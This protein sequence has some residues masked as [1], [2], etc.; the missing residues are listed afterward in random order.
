M[1]PEGLLRR[2]AHGEDRRPCRRYFE[3]LPHV[4]KTVSIADYLAQLHVALEEMP[5]ERLPVTGPCPRGTRLIAQYLLVYEASGDP[6]DF[7]EEIDFD[8]QRALVRGVL[9]EAH[10]SRNRQYRGGAGAL[11]AEEFNEPG[12]RAMLSGD[13]NLSYHWMSSAAALAFQRRAPCPWPSC[14]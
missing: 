12:M 4:G 3:S 6:T 5:P 2:A 1:S 13:V 8:Y 10:F 7:E 14:C 9:D 11:P